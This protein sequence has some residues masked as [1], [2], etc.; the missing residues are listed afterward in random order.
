MWAAATCMICCTGRL[1]SLV[2]VIPLSLLR[3]S[4]VRRVILVGPGVAVTWMSHGDPG[5]S[6][7]IP[8]VVRLITAR[9][10]LIIHLLC[11]QSEM[12]TLSW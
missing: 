8:L 12:I 3:D 5:S 7:V 10:R 11:H 4:T 2:A 6:T 1:A 9:V